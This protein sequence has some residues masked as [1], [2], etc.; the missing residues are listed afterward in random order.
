MVSERR[1]EADD[2][3]RKSQADCNQIGVTDRRKLYQTVDP[4]AD[5]FNHPSV[6][7]GIKHVAGD[8]SLNSLAHSQLAAT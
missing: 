1:D 4:P 7:E 3:V 8:A 2:G 6:S 5:L